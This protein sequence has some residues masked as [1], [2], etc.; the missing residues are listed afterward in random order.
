MDTMSVQPRGQAING[1]GF[2]SVT[3][4]SFG[5]GTVICRIYELRV[6]ELERKMDAIYLDQTKFFNENDCLLDICI[7]TNL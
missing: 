3:D 1:H 5:T 6:C 4:R 2:F 7:F